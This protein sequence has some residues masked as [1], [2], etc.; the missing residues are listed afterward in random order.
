M[1]RLERSLLVALGV[2]VL[3][4]IVVIFVGPRVAW[5]SSSPGER[6]FQVGETE[7]MAEA[8]GTAEHV[9]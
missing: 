9:P 2:L 8:A 5:P 1:S 7:T 3:L 6:P 4:A